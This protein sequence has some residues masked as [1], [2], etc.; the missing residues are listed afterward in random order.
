[1]IHFATLASVLVACLSWLVIKKPRG[2]FWNRIGVLFLTALVVEANGTITWQLGIHN[3]LVYTIYQGVELVLLMGV[4]HLTCAPLRPWTLPASVLG[5]VALTLDARFVHRET[6]FANTGITICAL[7]LAV[8]MLVMLWHRME[9]LN[10]QVFSDARIWL[11]LGMLLYFTA[12]APVLGS[13]EQI[14]R[15]YPRLATSLY[16]I[17]QVVCILR[18]ACAVAA[19][20]IQAS[21]HERTPVR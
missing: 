2:A 13:T 9:Q 16:L 5:V 8:A 1:M 11:Y 12:L 10:G 7:I 14:Y 6:L 18:Y 3:G 4:A 19:C 17:V 20:V 21:Q 15:R